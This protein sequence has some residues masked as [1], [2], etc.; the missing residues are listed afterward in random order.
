M[1][2]ANHRARVNPIPGTRRVRVVRVN[3]V[4]DGKGESSAPA[5]QL[6]VDRLHPS[7]RVT[8]ASGDALWRR[9][10]D[11]PQIALG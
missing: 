11:P 8:R 1:M 2:A 6:Q 9:R 3:V 10:V 7:F 5:N 4:A